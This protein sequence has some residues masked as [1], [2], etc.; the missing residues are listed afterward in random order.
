M[1]AFNVNFYD[2]NYNLV[3]QS[4][5]SSGETFEDALSEV[6]HHF[7]EDMIEN[8]ELKF[9]NEY[10]IILCDSSMIQDIIED[11]KE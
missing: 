5:I 3:E 2:I 4:G 10:N 7:G 9:I 1:F 8:L 6:V 11:N